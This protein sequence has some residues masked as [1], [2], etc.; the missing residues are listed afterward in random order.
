MTQGPSPVGDPTGGGG[1]A[2]VP[3]RLV[4]HLNS[5]RGVDLD[6]ALDAVAEAGYRAVELCASGDTGVRRH[7]A[8]RR[9]VARHG[10]AVAA[11]SGHSDLTTDDG[12]A[13][14][15]H[16]LTWA[17]EHGIGS[18]TTAIGGDVATA[19]DARG[20]LLG[21]LRALARAAETADVVVALEVHGRASGSGARLRPWVDAV[22]SP[23][24]RVKYD[25]ANC[26]Y[27]AGVA[28]V[29]DL[30]H[31]ADLVVN[32]D[33]KDKRGGP[34]VWDFPPPGDGHIDWPAV[35][36]VLDRAG[37][38]GP[39]TVEVEFRG[40]PWP[41]VERVTDALRRAATTLRPLLA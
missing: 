37:Y 10:L 2:A 18:M 7:P 14:A 39:L 11:L 29:D 28:A 20:T 15:L 33:A 12:L 16:N 34:G 40:H 3:D 31:V 26:E 5:F 32:V 38:A 35:V 4:A 30:P 23:W 8:P 1:P 6:T 25:T 13:A 19:E 27:Y 41:P 21:R 36:A 24:L 17:A 22:D 9:A